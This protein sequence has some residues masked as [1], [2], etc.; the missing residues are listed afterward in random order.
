[1]MLCSILAVLVGILSISSCAS[2]RLTRPSIPSPISL[3]SVSAL[4][5][6]NYNSQLALQLWG[7]YLEDLRISKDPQENYLALVRLMLYQ[8]T[9]FTLDIIFR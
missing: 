6:A 5:D 3:N 4:V 2:L 9:I 7:R 1:M 8:I